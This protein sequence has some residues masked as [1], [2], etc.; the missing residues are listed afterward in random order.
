MTT[1]PF[2]MTNTGRRL[3]AAPS[4]LRT[5]G[6]RRTRTV[7][8]SEIPDFLGEERAAYAG[9]LRIAV[10]D[11]ARVMP[12]LRHPDDRDERALW[13]LRV[14]SRAVASVDLSA[15]PFHDGEAVRLAVLPGALDD[16]EAALHSGP[17]DFEKGRVT[18][19]NRDAAFRWRKQMAT[20]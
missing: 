5:Q 10:A 11:A 2:T 9:R 13:R 1:A 17:R 16:A 7:D 6:T 14:R 18:G 20:S 4:F 15:L 12:P 8:P 3:T 19:R